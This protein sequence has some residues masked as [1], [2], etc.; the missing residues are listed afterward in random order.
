MRLKKI[1]QEQALYVRKRIWVSRGIVFLAALLLCAFVAA[2]AIKDSE[3]FEVT[4]YRMQSDKLTAGIRIA[5]LCDLHSCEYG[6]GNFTLIEEIRHRQPDLIIMAGDMVNDDDT[7]IDGILHLCENLKRIAPVCYILGNHEGTLMYSRNGNE[8]PLDT[9]LFQIG[10]DVIYSGSEIL[11]IKGNR[12]AVGAFSVPA[13]EA[14]RLDAESIQAFEAA[15]AF[16]IAVSHYPSIFYEHLYGIDADMALAG[17]Y[18]GGQI[19]LPWLG[20]LYHADDG[21]F[22]RYSG[23]EYTLLKAT[24]FVSRGLG[25]HGR[26]PR[27]NNRPEL[28]IID[29]VP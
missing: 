29:A 25:N 23:G 17:H 4:V 14:G 18:H 3:G 2:L 10:V 24:L 15:D 26:M 19:R 8:I 22:P 28:V 13:A 27:V 20:G 1:R 9:S 16:K 5:L 11:A 21:F 6:E 12:V 7:D